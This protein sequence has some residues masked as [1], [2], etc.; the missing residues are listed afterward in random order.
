ARGRFQHALAY[1]REA[2]LAAKRAGSMGAHVPSQGLLLMLRDQGGALD[3]SSFEPAEPHPAAPVPAFQRALY[4]T[5]LLGEGRRDEAHRI[6]R[7]LPPVDE[8]APF[9]HLSAY[10]T[11]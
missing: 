8:L 1:G 11:I 4:A 2:A 3:S 9:V 7:A 5:W 6:Y 10:A